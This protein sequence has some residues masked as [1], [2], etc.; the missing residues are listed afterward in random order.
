MDFGTQDNV[1]ML[2]CH[3]CQQM[4]FSNY[5]ELNEHVESC[6]LNLADDHGKRKLE[7]FNSNVIN[8]CYP[9]CYFLILNISGSNAMLF[10][11]ASNFLIE[12]VR[13]NEEKKTPK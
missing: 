7:V 1:D 2:Q 11:E 5:V 4:K 6:L 13:C 8:A 12:I 10:K 9:K 3:N